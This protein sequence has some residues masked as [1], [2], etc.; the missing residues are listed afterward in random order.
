MNFKSLKTLH[1]SSLQVMV[2]GMF[3]KIKKPY[4]SLRSYHRQNKCPVN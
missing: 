1:F 4:K 3:V 2:Y